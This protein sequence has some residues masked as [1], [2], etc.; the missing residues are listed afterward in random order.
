[1]RHVAER[2]DTPLEELYVQ[3]GWPLYKKY[4]H[5]FD[6]FKLAITYVYHFDFNVVREPDTVF[7]GLELPLEVKRDLLSNIR[8]RL[9]PQPIKIRADI[10]VTCFAYEGIDAVKAALQAGEACSTDQIAIKIKLVAPP[11]YVMVTYSTDRTLG[12]ETMEK[13]IEHIEQS[14]KSA[15]GAITIKMKVCFL[16]LFIQ[17]V[18]MCWFLL[19]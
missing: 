13:A 4:G 15:N 12:I 2:F 18:Q 5:A 10:E 7:E 8:R 6:A 9:T 11:L 19:D 14:I 17:L 16:P 3:F 1:M